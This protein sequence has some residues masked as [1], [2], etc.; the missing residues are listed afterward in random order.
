M[1]N[2]QIAAAIARTE[3]AIKAEKDPEK[4][5][6]LYANLSAYKKTKTHIEKHET[7]EGDPDADEDDDEDED[8]E[9]SK[10]DEEDAAAAKGDETVRTDAAEDDSDED[11]SDED[12]EESEE[13][14]ATSY[15]E[16]DEAAAK[17]AVLD[18]M[19]A[20]SA[21][22]LI[23]NKARKAIRQAV[24]TSVRKALANSR[25]ARVYA[26]VKKITGKRTVSGIEATL[27]G[28]VT[29]FRDA[30]AQLAQA[31]KDSRKARRS[32]MITAALNERRITPAEAKSLRKASLSFVEKTLAMKQGPIVY[33]NDGS[34][35]APNQLGPAS[36]LGGANGAA[37]QPD[38]MAVVNGLVE[39]AKRYGIDLDPAKM[40]EESAKK[41][42]AAPS[43]GSRNGG[44]V[45]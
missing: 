12:E 28:M 42:G 19:S 16:E 32:E 25:G 22:G 5:A 3:K 45:I 37:L 26:M 21:A 8:S 13:D 14:E 23:D 38:A 40:A 30:K 18:T 2:L 7:E 29:G 39:A 1:A 24:R 11:E 41:N 34:G 27:R 33:P 9:D 6:A 4:L 35:G 20:A 36:A 44:R 10:A 43:T 15:E 17:S 31:Q